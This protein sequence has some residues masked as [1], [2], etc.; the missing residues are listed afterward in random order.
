MSAA[1]TILPPRPKCG[2]YA[3]SVPTTCMVIR[4]VS[5]FL[6]GRHVRSAD[7]PGPAQNISSTS[8]K[9]NANETAPPNQSLQRTAPAVTLDAPPPW[10][11]SWLDGPLTV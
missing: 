5:T 11:V 10:T 6:V 3:L 2:S 8:L 1:A 7:G 9:L 4:R